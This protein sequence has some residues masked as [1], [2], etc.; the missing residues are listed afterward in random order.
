[1]TALAVF[2]FATSIAPGPNTLMLW[3][4]GMNFGLRRSTAHL[5]GVNLGFGS[6]MFAVSVG[7][8]AVFERY[9]PV[10]DALKILG[11]IY[12]LYLAYRIARSADGAEMGRITKPLSFREALAFQYVNPKVWVMSISA[13]GAFLPSGMSVFSASATLTAVFVFIHAPSVT[14]WVLSR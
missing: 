3:A 9:S 4:S 6:V 14:V 1:M 10:E 12:L 7:L 5:L 13:V 11:S 8:G 2:A